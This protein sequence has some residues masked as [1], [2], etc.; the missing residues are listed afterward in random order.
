[1]ATRQEIR[2]AIHDTLTTLVADYTGQST[3]EAAAHVALSERTADMKLPGYTFS[4]FTQ[5]V[6]RGLHD[7]EVRST[8]TT[9]EDIVAMY[10]APERAVV[11]TGVHA[12]NDDMTVV[13]DLYNR[14]HNALTRMQ[15][16]VPADDQL[17]PDVERGS[18]SIGG[19]QDQSA[20]DSH[21]VGERLRF[22][23]VYDALNTVTAPTM[24]E[25]QTELRDV[26]A[27]VE[28]TTIS[29]TV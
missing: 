14:L 22:E 6:Q 26:D 29:H 25:I 5:P 16:Q 21:V 3:E 24:Q 10:A 11:D 4:L 13:S 23:F 19:S 20:R 2:Q 17:H 18:L 9:G 15:P 1:M 7:L 8:D 12:A 28:Y 27:D